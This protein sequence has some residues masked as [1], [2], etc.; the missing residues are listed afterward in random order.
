MNSIGIVLMAA[1]PE[2]PTKI[3]SVLRSGKTRLIIDSLLK[4]RAESDRSLGS[5]L[6]VLEDHLGE[7][8]RRLPDP[9]AEGA[10]EAADLV[11]DFYFL[12]A[13]RDD[14]RQAAGF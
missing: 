1:G 10:G 14:V 6:R 3:E 4:E 11:I 5:V 2:A 9:E 7:L 13:I 12:T 8:E